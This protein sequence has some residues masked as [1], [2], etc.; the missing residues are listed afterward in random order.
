[1]KSTRKLLAVLFASVLSLSMLAGAAA[2]GDG[3]AVDVR[4]ELGWEMCAVSVTESEVNFDMNREGAFYVAESSSVVNVEVTGLNAFAGPI[5]LV[6]AA[7]EGG[8][9]DGPGPYYILQNRINASVPVQGGGHL[10]ESWFLLSGTTV[11][12][13]LEMDDL[14]SWIYAPGEYTG[15]LNITVNTGS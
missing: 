11:P 6:D 15:T 5:C 1:M 9:L 7:L 3:A 8:Q 4:A 12:V 13:T 10:A 2:E 14:E